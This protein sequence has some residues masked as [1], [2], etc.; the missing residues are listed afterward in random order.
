MV[1][2]GATLVAAYGLD[3]KMTEKL[4]RSRLLELNEKLLNPRDYTE[5]ENDDFFLRFCAGSPDPIGAW[6]LL[7]ECLDPMTSEETVDR[8]HR[9]AAP[10]DGGRDI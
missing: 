9:D 3:L 2:P 4:R 8:A 5:E 1:A 6:W 7:V 10:P